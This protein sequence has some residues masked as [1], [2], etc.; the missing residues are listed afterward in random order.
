MQAKNTGPLIYKSLNQK[1]AYGVI[2]R[3]RWYTCK[4]N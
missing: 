1:S 2:L 3:Y 4:F